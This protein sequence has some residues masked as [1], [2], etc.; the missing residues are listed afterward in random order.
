MERLLPKAKAARVDL[1]TSPPPPDEKPLID[2]LWEDPKAREELVG[3]VLRLERCYKTPL[4]VTEDT[5]IA[6]VGI[7]Y[8]DDEGDN[9]Y[10]DHDHL[11]MPAGH[12]PD[13][14]FL[15]VK[16]YAEWKYNVAR[17][18]QGVGAHG[19]A[20]CGMGGLWI[21]IAH[22]NEVRSMYQTATKG[23]NTRQILAQMFEAL[24]IDPMAALGKSMADRG[25]ELRQIDDPLICFPLKAR[26]IICA[27][28]IRRARAELTKNFIK[29]WCP[30]MTPTNMRR[31]F[32]DAPEVTL[33][34][35][36]C[37]WPVEA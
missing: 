17:P 31:R 14:F 25:R 18:K 7:E 35:D 27:E 36:Y 30:L 34:F 10:V 6:I 16:L 21:E 2:V 37:N 8:E 12:L 1:T 20:R 11:L 32:L 29:E 22:P 28:L 15:V 19:V 24:D 9:G 5:S 33:Y 13:W 26:T 3:R 4:R 23:V